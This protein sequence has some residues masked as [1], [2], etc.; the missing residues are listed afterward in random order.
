VAAAAGALLA[1][2]TAHAVA[3]AMGGLV[4]VMAAAFLAT[5]VRIGPEFPAIAA[6]AVLPRV[7]EGADLVVLGLVGTTVVPYNLFLGSGLAC[8]QS[9]AEIRLGLAVA[10]GLGVLVSMAVVVVGTA[11]GTPFTFGGLAAALG[12]RLGAWAATAFAVGLAGAGFSSAVTA[13][14]AAAI[15]AA[16]LFGGSGAGSFG[17]SGARYRAVWA[18]VLVTG[19]AFGLAGFR[20]VP[21]ILTVQALNGILLPFVAA[22]LL[23]VV[24]DRSIM[25]DRIN[26]SLANVAAGGTVMVTISLGTWGVLRAATTAIGGRPPTRLTVLVI[27][28]AVSLALLAPLARAIVRVRRAV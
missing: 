26:G 11:A 6:G 18:V 14:L 27:T 25:G 24:N 28:A 9:L 13:P 5:A 16:G 21:L 8:G 22:F 20:P 4:A 10:I 1:T 23:L 2:G 12:E 17:E 15:T 3:R 7:P 19:L